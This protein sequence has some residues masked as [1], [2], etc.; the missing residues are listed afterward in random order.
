MSIPAQG[1]FPAGIL[2]WRPGYAVLAVSVFLIEVAIALWVR[3]RFIRPYLGDVLAVLLVY[4]AL[5]AV[6]AL[7][8]FPAVLNAFG[9]GVAVELAQWLRL[10]DHLGLAEGSAARVALGSHFDFHDILCYAAGA[11]IILI[12]ERWRQTPGD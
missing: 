2:R 9:V 4:F 3:D 6:T 12:V 1:R 8:V 11:A 5:R 7:R 10:S